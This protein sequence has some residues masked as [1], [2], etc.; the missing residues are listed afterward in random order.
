[1][2]YL[3][4]ALSFRTEGKIL[5]GLSARLLEKLDFLNKITAFIFERGPEKMSKPGMEKVRFSV[6]E[7]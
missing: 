1:L 3:P 5:Q 4:R 2:F 7:N 6:T